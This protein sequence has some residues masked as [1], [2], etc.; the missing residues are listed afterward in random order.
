MYFYSNEAI[1]SLHRDDTGFRNE[2]VGVK[3]SRKPKDINKDRLV[4]TKNLQTTSK[5]LSVPF[6]P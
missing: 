6:F 1:F 5:A 3:G 2:N 4:V